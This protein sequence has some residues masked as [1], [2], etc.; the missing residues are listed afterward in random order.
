MTGEDEWGDIFEATEDVTM[1]A[2]AEPGDPNVLLRATLLIFWCIVRVPLLI[3][4]GFLEPLI[5][6]L[7]SGIAVLSVLTGLVYQGSSV[8]PP[9]PFW[10]MLCISVGCL[11][12]VAAYHGLLQWL[13]R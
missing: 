9:I 7:L 10:V 2:T 11:L 12:L 5:R 8:T 3:V 13:S 6:L 4:L 1:K